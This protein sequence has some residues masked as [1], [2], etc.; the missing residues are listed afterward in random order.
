[1]PA[2]RYA[3][4]AAIWV[5]GTQLPSHSEVPDSRPLL[6]DNCRALT[7]TRSR[8][9]ISRAISGV[10]TIA[11]AAPSLT[12]QQSN[13]PRGS[14]MIGARRIASIST[15]RRRCALGFLDPFLWLFQDTCAIARLSSSR[16]KP[17]R[18]AYPDASCAKPAGA[19]QYGIHRSLNVPLV[20]T[21]SPPKP[22][23]LSF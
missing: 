1:M 13:T 4:L 12:P 22:V 23:S 11:Q 14:A 8:F 16:P 3:A 17:N 15:E 2:S 10:V 21:G 19:E 18:A 7:V 20:G 6:A 5:L 9:P